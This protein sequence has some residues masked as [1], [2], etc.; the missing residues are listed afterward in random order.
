ME[1]ILAKKI[2]YEDLI[3]DLYL[4]WRLERKGGRVTTA[5]LIYLLE[6]ELFDKNMIGPRYKMFKH[7][8]G[9]YNLNIGKH[10][11]DLSRSGFL[12][13]NVHY[14]EKRKKDVKTYYSNKKTEQFIENI[15]E[16]IQ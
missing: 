11:T 5:K 16:L 10:L 7:D 15:D 9:P 12:S 3:I 8:M 13:Y 14:F 6:D 2:D 4:F 1:E